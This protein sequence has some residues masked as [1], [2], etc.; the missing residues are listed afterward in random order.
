MY[1]ASSNVKF[2][3]IASGGVDLDSERNERVEAALRVG[4]VEFTREGVPA[5]VSAQF[6]RGAVRRGERVA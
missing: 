2:S 3:R 1:S 5:Q 4:R 6:D